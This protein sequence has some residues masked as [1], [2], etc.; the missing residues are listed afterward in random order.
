[1]NE[2]RATPKTDELRRKREEAYARLTPKAPEA[3]K[4]A[5]VEKK[6]EIKAPARKK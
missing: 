5:A 2:K 4:K 3:A 6:P 1:M